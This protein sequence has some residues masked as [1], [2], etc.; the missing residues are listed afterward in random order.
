M[1]HALRPTTTPEKLLEAYNLHR[2]RC[3]ATKKRLAAGEFIRSFVLKPDRAAVFDEFIRWCALRG[4]DPPLMLYASFAARGWLWPP[5][6]RMGDLTGSKATKIYI[7]SR[8][9][10]G[11]R[12]HLERAAA[13]PGRHD[14]D[15]N[16]DLSPMVEARKHRLQ[17]NPGLCLE[18]MLEATLGYHPKSEICLRCALAEDCKVR[19]EAFCRPIPMIKLRAGLM[20]RE[21]AMAMARGRG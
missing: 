14:F 13:P 15:P 2:M 12:R 10:D 6:I 1:R 16:I 5:Q 18:L 19:L 21:A 3:A 11:Y 7:S 20:T 9:L 17:Q 4:Y 8:Y